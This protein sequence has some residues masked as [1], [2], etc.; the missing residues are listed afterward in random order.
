MPNRQRW[1]WP[2]L[3]E[4]VNEIIGCRPF[5]GAKREAPQDK[6]NHAVRDRGDGANHCLCPYAGWS[7]AAQH[8]EP[9]C[10]QREDIG[11][12]IKE[13]RIRLQLGRSETP[14]SRGL[15]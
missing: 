9:H 11:L 1:R 14:P 10:A 13:L 2:Q 6:F 12:R 4:F 5:Y 3:L 15:I 8:S 7:L